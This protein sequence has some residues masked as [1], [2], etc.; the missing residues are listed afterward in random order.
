MA[1]LP[2]PSGLIP[3]TP[4][5]GHHA[6]SRPSSPPLSR[7]ADQ[8]PP[9]PVCTPL[10]ACHNLYWPCHFI[11]AW[12]PW[13]TT[14]TFSQPS[15][16]Q[17]MQ[18]NFNCTQFLHMKWQLFILLHQWLLHVLYLNVI[19]CHARIV[20][21]WWCV[22]CIVGVSLCACMWQGVSVC[23][24]RREWFLLTQIYFLKRLFCSRTLNK[25]LPSLYCRILPME[26]YN[27]F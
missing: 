6:S 25:D 3:P 21:K 13:K 11:A 20:R 12:C 18:W 23:L 16:N 8:W 2:S 9:A 26:D 22:Q 14:T 19:S 5:T 4:L 27:D 15:Y 1:S 10:Q 24:E 17:T 7:H